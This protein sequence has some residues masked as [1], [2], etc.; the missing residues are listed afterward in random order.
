MISIIDWRMA[1]CEKHGV[2]FHFN[3]FA[4]GSD[5]LA[6][7][8]NEVIIANRRPAPYGGPVIRE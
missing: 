2:Q 3:T 4:E 6:T 1:Q 5:I 8:P 7:D